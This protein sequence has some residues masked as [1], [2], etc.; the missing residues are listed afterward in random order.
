MNTLDLDTWIPRAI[1]CD[2]QCLHS[3]YTN[4]YYISDY[5]HIWTKKIYIYDDTVDRFFVVAVFDFVSNCGL[6]FSLIHSLSFLF[7]VKITP[8]E[9][10]AACHFCELDANRKNRGNKVPAE[11]KTPDLQYLNPRCDHLNASGGQV[12]QHP[13]QPDDLSQNSGVVRGTTSL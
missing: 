8:F 7:F 11:K 5:I 10:F 12:G 6:L 13:L 4:D 2:I 9:R 3:A 1:N